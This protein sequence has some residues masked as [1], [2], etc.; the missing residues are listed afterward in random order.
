MPFQIDEE[1]F[2]DPQ[3]TTF[4]ISAPQGSPTGIP[5]KQIPILEFPRC[6]YMHPKEPL[7]TIEHRNARHEIVDIETV[8]AEAESRVVKD[9]AEMQAA[10]KQGWRKEPYIQPTQEQIIAMQ[11]AP[12]TSGKRSA[13]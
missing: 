4:D 8:L 12:K 10:L 3:R 11:E 6:M 1:K 7:K 13:A 2:R 9:E 5:V